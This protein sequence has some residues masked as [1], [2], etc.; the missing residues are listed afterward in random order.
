[1]SRYGEPAEAMSAVLVEGPRPRRRAWITL[2]ICGLL[3][4]AVNAAANRGWGVAPVYVAKIVGNDWGWLGACGLACWGGRTWAIAWARGVA[5]LL[6]AL[7]VY[8]GSDVVLGAGRQGASYESVAGFLPE[9]T[10]WTFMSVAAS[11]GVGL[12][13]IIVRRGGILGVAA[14][15]AVPAYI[16]WSAYSTHS[17]LVLSNNVDPAL[18]RVTAVLWPASAVSVLIIVTAGC[19]RVLSRRRRSIALRQHDNS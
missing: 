5:V 3:L 11:A 8:F 9:I 1:M 13:V 14:S 18:E 10:F 17:W 7:I 15:A 4:G 6:P 16:A 2:V 12:L 19:L